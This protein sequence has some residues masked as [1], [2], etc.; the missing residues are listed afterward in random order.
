M[1]NEITS[2]TNIGF[3]PN[4]QL[5]ASEV[6]EKRKKIQRLLKS[7]FRND[8]RSSFSMVSDDNPVSDATSNHIGPKSIPSN[9]KK[10]NPKPQ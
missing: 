9:T 8:K 10:I 6:M 7:N 5:I 3:N 4:K 1:N 2:R